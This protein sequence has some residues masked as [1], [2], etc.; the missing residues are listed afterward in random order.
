[1][2]KFLVFGVMVIIVASSCQNKRERI[3]N[4]NTNE[5]IISG[6]VSYTVE[7]GEILLI[8]NDIVAESDVNYLLSLDSNNCFSF[9]GKID[10]PQSFIL[11]IGR[12][13]FL[14]LVFPSDSVF[15]HVSDTLRLSCEN[16]NHEGLSNYLIS[17]IKIFGEEYKKEAYPNMYEFSKIPV[18]ESKELID[19]RRENLIRA[20]DSFNIRNAITDPL[21][22]KM[23]YREIDLRIATILMDYALFRKMLHKI[24][25]T[26][27]DDF[28][29]FVDSLNSNIN[30]LIVTPEFYYFYNRLSA[31]NHEIN[32]DTFKIK[33][34][35][36]G[37]S[38][39]R[40]IVLSHYIGIYINNKD[41]IKAGNAL[42]L[43]YDE[44]D[45]EII[46]HELKKRYQKAKE[47]LENPVIKNA[48]LS[49]FS[50]LPEAGSVLSE[51]ISKHK[52][53]VLYLKFW[54]PWCGPC[55]A[56][57]PFAD[58]LVEEFS[59]KDFALI[60]L[61]VQTPKDRWKAT[62]AEKGLSGYQYLMNEKQYQQLK[63]L[64][65]IPGIP[66]YVL[67]DKKGNIVNGNAPIPGD[68]VFAGNPGDSGDENHPALG[69]SD[70]MNS[71]LIEKLKMLI[72]E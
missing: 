28:F 9:R 45:N 11:K 33:I 27:P 1:M 13:P 19:F 48:M 24:E 17:V 6:K 49:D 40:D 71:E 23:A 47:I 32:L 18:E 72:K 56:Q 35:G 55:V 62:I 58:K 38:L 39:S 16:K 65:Q 4:A 67:I 34:L 43:F 30:E 2:R 61:C 22:K 69:R 8:P 41:T 57:I 51:I 37:R 25:T 70:G 7:S 29:A 64:F 44:I 14:F 12:K 36:K 31:I 21:Y 20:I 46:K 59:P 53:K 50:N 26:L 10:F 3:T 60:N 15:L 5:I 54:A 68:V 52:N 42:N 63:V 66:H